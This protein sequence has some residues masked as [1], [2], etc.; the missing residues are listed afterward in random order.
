MVIMPTDLPETKANPDAS[1]GT[2][3]GWHIL[4]IFIVAFGIVFTV[5]GF[6]IYKAITTNSGE[7]HHAYME[8][9]KFNETLETR[10]KQKNLGWDMTLS[11]NRGAGGDALFSA[12]MLDKN[13][14]PVTGLN[15]NG[16]LY[17]NT[18]NKDDH[19]LAFKEVKAGIYESHVANLGA[20]KWLFE[21]KAAKAGSPDFT[22][23]TSLSIR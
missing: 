22:T 5:N 9:L 11:M 6:F 18:E 23:E 21:A 14:Q 10:A 20:G 8:G 13:G 12:Q 4:T 1:K 15:I 19:K 7:I 16:L 17:R 2:L 3:T